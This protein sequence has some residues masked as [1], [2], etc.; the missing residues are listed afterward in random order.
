MQTKNLTKK[1][2]AAALVGPER[3]LRK[4]RTRFIG[5]R[6]T[7][8]ASGTSVVRGMFLKRKA[9]TSLLQNCPNDFPAAASRASNC[10][11]WWC[12]CTSD[13]SDACCVPANL[14][15]NLCHMSSRLPLNVPVCLCCQRWEKK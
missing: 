11:I 8:V 4:H 9:K 5:G 15:C 10:G 2:T 3:H 12:F 1:R 13:E 14:A 6:Y 7:L